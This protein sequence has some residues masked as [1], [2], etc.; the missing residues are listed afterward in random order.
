MIM[1]SSWQQRYAARTH[2]LVKIAE[3]DYADVRA[4]TKVL[5]STP[6][7]IAEMLRRIPLGS[8]IT[9]RELREVLARKHFALKACPITTGIYLH[10][11]AEVALDEMAD[12]TPISEVAPFWRVVTPSSNLAQKL[13]CGPAGV[14]ALRANEGL[15]NT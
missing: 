5:I 11:V 15:P 10:I 4:G 12:G 14:R 6:R 7:E 2:P 8:E 9:F 13:S 1:R 3:H